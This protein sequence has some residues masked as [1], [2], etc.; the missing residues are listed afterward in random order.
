MC[1][2]KVQNCNKNQMSETTKSYICVCERKKQTRLFFI[3][4]IFFTFKF[5]V[6]LEMKIFNDFQN[7]TNG[8]IMFFINGKSPI[9][10]V[11]PYVCNTLQ[12][13]TN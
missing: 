11:D 2:N 13:Y 4:L 6:E 5:L 12:L 3:K 7:F 9:L 1:Q 8:K 10:S